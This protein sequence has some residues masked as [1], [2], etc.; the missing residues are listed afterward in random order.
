M[1][2]AFFLNLYAQAGVCNLRQTDP[3]GIVY[4][5]NHIRPIPMI[6]VHPHVHARIRLRIRLIL[7]LTAVLG[8]PRL[9]EVL[10]ETHLAL[11]GSLFHCLG[12]L[13]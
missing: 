3:I 11:L 6:A 2:F 4:V 7:V 1:R 5:V 8:K 13:G 10:S 12:V 9:A